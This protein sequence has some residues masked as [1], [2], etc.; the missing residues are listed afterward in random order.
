MTKYILPKKVITSTFTQNVYKTLIIIYSFYISFS[1]QVFALEVEAPLGG[2]SFAQVMFDDT[3]ALERKKQQLESQLRA[4][5]IA[6]IEAY[7]GQYDLPLQSEAEHFIDAAEEH[8]IDWRLVAA[9]GF[10]ESTGGKFACETADYSAFGWG[11]CNIDFDSY[12]ESIDVISMNLGGH[13]PKTEQYYA[14]K[15]IRGILE[16]YNPPSIVPDYAD[17]VIKQMKKIS[18]NA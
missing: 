18:P 5:R 11:S 7:Y 14:G 10:I 9:I 15:D 13:N 3:A 17:K 4:E 8:G 2:Q 12:A 16:A 6:K 1:A